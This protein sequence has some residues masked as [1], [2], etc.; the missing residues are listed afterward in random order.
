VLLAHRELDRKRLNVT[1]RV[2]RR[3]VRIVDEEQFGPA[4]PVMSFRDV[5][6]AIERANASQFGLAASV[7]TS[8]PARAV[9]VGEQLEAGTTWINTHKV[10]S[11]RQPF[12]GRKWS[13]LGI[14]GGVWGLDANSD[15]ELLYTAR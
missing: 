10:L 11:P 7:W 4:L 1:R 12:A 9:P 3:G 8:D 14:E 5:D 2:T 13:G 6:D 15:V